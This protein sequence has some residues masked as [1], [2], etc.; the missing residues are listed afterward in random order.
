MGSGPKRVTDARSALP[1][2]TSA[3]AD[4]PS[5]DWEGRLYVGLRVAC[6]PA[7]IRQD[8]MRALGEVGVE[9]EFYLRLPRE[10]AAHSAWAPSVGEQFLRGLE[11]SAGRLTRAAAALEVAAQSYLT[12]LEGG[13]AGV[14][15][16]SDQTDA[17]WPPFDGYAPTGESIELLLRRCGFAYRHVVAVHLASNIEAIAEQ[18]ALTLHALRTLP[19]AGTVPASALYRGL[20]ELSAALHGYI[21]AHHIADV[22]ERTP[23]LLS[24][25]AHLRDLAQREDTALEADIAWAQGQYAFVRDLSTQN[26]GGTPPWA[27]GALREWRETMTAL[28]RLRSG[29]AT[30][31][32]R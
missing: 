29:A 19:P 7:A 14:R 17:W 30:A 32:D 5:L 1:R 23:G 3:A 2:G 6:V 4:T 12:A 24:G 11:S 21:V 26:A 18:M 25:I 27:D 28:E 13:Y 10:L 8:L 16:E 31:F 20:Y 22:N 15:A 9:A